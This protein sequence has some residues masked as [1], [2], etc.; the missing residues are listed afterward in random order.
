VLVLAH[1]ASAQDGEVDARLTWA[2]T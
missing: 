2:H 1:E